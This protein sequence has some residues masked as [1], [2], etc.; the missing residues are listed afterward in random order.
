MGLL[1]KD[2]FVCID[3]ETTGLDPEND[4]IIEIAIISFSFSGTIESYETLVN[5]N[6]LIP[7]ES[8]AIHHIDDSMV[9]NK[10]SIK[11]VLPKVLEIAN[12]YPIMGHGVSF[13]IQCIVNAAKKFNIPCQLSN[14]KVLDTLR[15]ARN[16]GNSPVN[17][18]EE[19]R[20]HFNI[21]EEGAHRAMSD[22]LVNIQVFKHLCLTFTKTETL[23]KILSKPIL[24]KT[25]P[26]GKHKGRL[27]KE[28]P[29]AYLQWASKQNFDQDLIHSLRFA[30][31]KMKKQ[32]N[33]AQAT[34]PF[35]QL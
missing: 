21:Q 1:K 9:A 8:Q 5:P 17:S 10:P 27:I 13:D 12:D 23:Y 28:I 32:S 4:Q 25:M 2:I 14:N 18:L 24:L 34:N 11:E 16:Y 15:L 33:F 20:K 7:I 3:C 22:V 6:R 35:N 30:L 31:K 29:L 19:L 26:L